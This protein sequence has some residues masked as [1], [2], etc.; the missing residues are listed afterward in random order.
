MSLSERV[1]RVEDTLGTVLGGVADIGAELVVIAD[2]LCLKEDGVQTSP[3]NKEMKDTNVDVATSTPSNWQ[4]CGGESHEGELPADFG[5]P[6]GPQHVSTQHT[7]TPL[8]SGL[9]HP[10]VVDTDQS[11]HSA[12]GKAAGGEPVK[13]RDSAIGARVHTQPRMRVKP[14]AQRILG[15]ASPTIG[16]TATAESSD[17]PH[18][19][20]RIYNDPPGSADFGSALEPEFAPPLL[21]P[22]KIGVNI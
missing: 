11:S 12:H 15:A 8:G 7:G 22:K 17:N 10:I 3:K 20:A 1:A 19:C 13:S 18:P 4:H 21:R 5:S 9:Q 14:F 16:G 6:T 2:R